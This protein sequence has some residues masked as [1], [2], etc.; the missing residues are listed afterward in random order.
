MKVESRLFLFL[1][2]FFGVV[3]LGYAGVTYL[4][5]GHVEVIGTTVFL[6]TFLMAAMISAYLHLVGR[7]ID[8]RPEDNKDG[9][10]IDGAGTLGFFPP[11]SIWPFWAAVV[12]SVMLLGP[13]FGWWITVLGA[14]A[15]IWAVSG[16]CYEYY[17][18][19]YRH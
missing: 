13:V 1:V 16:W 8:L 14:C 19:E 3:S 12:T 5:D 9:E 18:G 15:G 17:V 10:I 4:L 6:L 2:I 11:S 7:G